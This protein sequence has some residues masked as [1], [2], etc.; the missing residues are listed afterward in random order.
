MPA[1]IQRKSSSFSARPFITPNASPPHKH[2]FCVHIGLIESILKCMKRKRTRYQRGLANGAQAGGANERDSV[3]ASGTKSDAG[4][5]SAQLGG[6]AIL[7]ELIEDSQKPDRFQRCIATPMTVNLTPTPNLL[8]FS[9][10]TKELTLTRRAFSESPP[11]PTEPLGASFDEGKGQVWVVVKEVWDDNVKA[12]SSVFGSRGGGEEGCDDEGKYSSGSYNVSPN[13][14]GC[15]LTPSPYV[16]A[17]RSQLDSFA[18]SQVNRC[19]HLVPMLPTPAPPECRCWYFTVW[20]FRDLGLGWSQVQAAIKC[21]GQIFTPRLQAL[22]K[23]N[24]YTLLRTSGF[25]VPYNRR[26]HRRQNLDILTITH[27]TSVTPVT[28]KSKCSTS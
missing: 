23:G 7:G 1:H 12:F 14:H 25:T 17:Q 4:L 8:P 15:S 27:V 19:L 9:T 24:P 11:K 3:G 18:S 21:L 5:G 16:P 2:Q 26:R 10:F 28:Y 6:K 22:T 20:A 13:P